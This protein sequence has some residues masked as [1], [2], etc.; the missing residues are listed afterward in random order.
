MGQFREKGQDPSAAPEPKRNPYER[1]DPR[2]P[3]QV[4][5]FCVPSTQKPVKTTGIR[6][7]G[8]VCWT[9]QQVQ[10]SGLG[11]ALAV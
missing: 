7:P 10:M 9:D 8:H 1:S 11:G 5:D 6:R 2:T 3:Q 4:S